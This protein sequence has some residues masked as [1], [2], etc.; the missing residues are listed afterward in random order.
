MEP[1][2][3]QT[4]KRRTVAE[5]N[6][7][8]YIDVMLVLL[9]IFMVTAP[10]LVQTVPVNLPEVDATPTEI[11]PDDNTLIIAVNAA[12]LYFIEREEDD[13]QAMIL[14]DVVS[15]AEKIS[16]VTPDTKL[17]IRGDK[18][19]PYGKVVVLMGQL[20]GVGI[21]NVGLITEA[22]DPNEVAQ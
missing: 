3:Q 18:N 20:Q 22:P 12:G 8:P 5:I 4:S 14:S 15:Y 9:I 11:D 17:M 1:M 16:T 2:P 21:T 13:P 7:V 6:V 19:V 10:M